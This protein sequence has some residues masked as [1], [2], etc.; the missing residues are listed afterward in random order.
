M[1]SLQKL[2]WEVEK[3]TQR[4]Q[5]GAT[6]YRQQIATLSLEVLRNVQEVTPFFKRDS[7]LQFVSNVLKTVDVDRQMD[8]AKML[9]VLLTDL[10]TRSQLSDEFKTKLEERRRKRKAVSFVL[11]K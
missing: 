1:A 5:A 9:H 3:E 2:V 8:V 6:K 11:T 7:A 10:T 4:L